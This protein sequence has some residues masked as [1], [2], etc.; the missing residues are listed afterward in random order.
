MKSTE[1]LIKKAIKTKN[2]AVIII[3][4][5]ICICTV[6]LPRMQMKAPITEID[7]DSYLAVHYIDVGQGDSTLITT[8][9]GDAMLIDTGPSYAEDALLSYLYAWDIKTIDYL[10]L[11]HPHEDHMGSAE[12]VLDRFDVEHLIMPD[13]KA[14]S[15]DYLNLIT[16]TDYSDTQ[17]FRAVPGTVY[18]LGDAE[19]TIL[20]PL[21]DEYE[22]ENNYSIITRVCYLDLSFLFTGDAEQLAEEELLARYTRG[23]LRSDIYKAGHH[24]SS[25]SS[26]DSFLDAVSPSVAIISCELYNPYGHPHREV[27]GA[28]SERGITVCRTD[29]EGTVVIETDGKNYTIHKQKNYDSNFSQ[30]LQNTY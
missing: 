13:M 19:F 20:G 16:D 21:D 22:S 2:P 15:S 5:I 18:S 26:C 12:A 27:L 6:L 17:F 1:K 14:A 4:V 30:K 23:E 8:A 7:E 9:D 24:G 29:T 28:F 10:I 3:A 11:T 25:T